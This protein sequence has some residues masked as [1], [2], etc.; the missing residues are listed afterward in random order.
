MLL[1]ASATLN[2]KSAPVPSKK[3]TVKPA[4]EQAD[5]QGIDP[6]TA[7]RGGTVTVSGEF[8]SEPVDITIELKNVDGGPSA[9]T[10]HPEKVTLKEDGQSFT[11]SIPRTAPL[12]KYDVL[13]TFQK[14]GTKYG[15]LTVPV[16]AGGSFRVVTGQP[17]KIDNVYP[18]VSYP[19][20]DTFGFKIIGEGFSPIKEDNSLFI[21]GRGVVPLCSPQGT[22]VNC[23]N[24]EIIDPGREIR[25]SGLSRAEYQGVQKVRIRVGDEY[26]E[27][28]IAVTLSQVSRKM[29]ALISIGFIAA[30]V[31]LIWL[32]L[33]TKNWSTSDGRKVS[34]LNA[35]F[36]EKDTNTYSLSKLQFYLWTLAALF[37]Y[38]YL[39][40]SRSL[41]QWTFEFAD[42]PENLPG[43]LLVTVSTSAL[44]VGITNAK[45]SKGAGEQGP[46]LA[47][48]VTTGGVVAAE[49]IQF[50]VWT[51][52]GVGAFVFLTLSTEPGKIENLPAVPE[53]FL[54]LMG[55]SS[56]G[57]LGG[58]LARKPGPV[59]TQ[60]V[61]ETGSLILQIHGSNLSPDATF[62]IDDQDLNPTVLDKEAQPDGRPVVVTKDDD[63][64]LAK[65]LRF[66]IAEP[67]A[68]WLTGTHDFTITNPD[69]QKAVLAFSAEQDSSSTSGDAAN[70]AAADDHKDKA[71]DD[72][73]DGTTED[74]H[75]DNQAD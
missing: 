6:E 39:S 11:F 21:E 26:S 13:V 37:G 46:S 30:I 41:V 3:E 43:I 71:A 15:P 18:V 51:L 25:F 23:V 65:I 63:P 61:A 48:F 12:G 64:G 27:K 62:K 34:T 50:L 24:E 60:I 44:A 22:T 16:T 17:V 8:P 70:D 47:D 52:V 29:P 56:F 32:L 33:E 68:K 31:G 72:Q 40:V 58:K 74:N 67:L 73:K 54:Y 53:R 10:V 36:L 42:I 5:V 14:G 28:P 19:E 20:K 1:L 55:I 57:Y 9:K 4:P 59:I 49:R 66:T 7:G 75:N 38:V 2:S 35:A 69:G 45:G